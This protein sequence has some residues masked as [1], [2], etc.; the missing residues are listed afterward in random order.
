MAIDG[1]KDKIEKLL[2]KA[3]GAATPEE[4]EAYQSKAEA[5]MIQWGIDEAEL[6]SRDKTKREEIIEVKLTFKASYGPTMVLF[7]NDIC[8]GF[9]NLRVLQSSIGDGDWRVFYIIGH[10]SDV[11]AVQLLI[12]S[13]QMQAM[14]ELKKWQRTAPERKIMTDW[15]KWQSNR[16]FLLS[17]SQE[18]ERR[19]RKMRTKLE[20]QVKGTGTELVLV[21]RKARV[22]A[23]MDEQYPRLRKSRGGMSG[24][25]W[26]GQA[27]REAGARAN[28]ASGSLSGGRTGISS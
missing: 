3:A 22:D 8:K 17:F 9:G 12:A 10:K 2:A 27:G 19:L 16:Q 28:I 18:V 13:L 21:D 11:E 25:R 20:D 4:Q 6:E 24:S 5:L 15:Q 23:W 7:A 1:M 14:T 26:G